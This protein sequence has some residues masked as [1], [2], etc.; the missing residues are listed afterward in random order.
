[1]LLTTTQKK[2]LDQYAM[3]HHPVYH[4]DEPQYIARLLGKVVTVS[5]ETMQ[6]IDELMERVSVVYG[7]SV[8]ENS[9]SS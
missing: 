3:L 5:I 6:L 2:A 1:M 4:E 9:T 7:V 8:V